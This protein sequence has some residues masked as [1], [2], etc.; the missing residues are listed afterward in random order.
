MA[1]QKANG[2]WCD[3][4]ALKVKMA[5]FGKEYITKNKSTKVTQNKK[6]MEDIQIIEAGYQ[7]KMTYAEVVGGSGVTTNTIKTIKAYEKGN[8]WFYESAV[9][10]LKNIF[11][12]G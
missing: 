12:S 6:T 9:A 10:R 4:R 1:V 5:D 2:L 11:F 3:H 8:G 7:R